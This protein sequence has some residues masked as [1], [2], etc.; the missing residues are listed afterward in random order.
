M[1][2]IEGSRNAGKTY[3]L[4]R[5]LKENP[6]KFYTYKFPYYDLYEKL[7]LEKEL[8]AGTYFSF[9]KDLD[10]LSLA[11]MNLLP[12]NIVLDRGFVSTIIFAMIFR[13]AKEEQMTQYIELIKEKYQSVKIDIVYVEPNINKRNSLGLSEGREKDINELP[14]LNL[15]GEPILNSTYSFKYNWV[16]EQL[17]NQPNI[18]IH[19]FIN[20][21]DEESVN[22]FNY[23]LNMLYKS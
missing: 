4:E 20:N 10:L 23:M 12:D 22:S 21:F 16:I 7:N 9:G 5:Y 8:N 17:L 15:V 3:L 1:I 19:K 6:N 13:G 2:Y 18:A 11:K 14:S